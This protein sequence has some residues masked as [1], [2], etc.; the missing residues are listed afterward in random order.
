MSFG[1][2]IN[3]LYIASSASLI[4]DTIW[5]YTFRSRL[6]SEHVSTGLYY[7]CLG[8]L[9]SDALRYVFSNQ[10]ERINKFQSMEQTSRKRRLEL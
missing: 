2:F 3:G 1:A 8:T 6:L 4:A 10:I 5:R 9:I 7:A